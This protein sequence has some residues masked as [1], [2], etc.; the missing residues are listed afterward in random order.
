[1]SYS[2]LLIARLN[3]VR[4]GLIAAEEEQKNV[5]ETNEILKKQYENLK[6]QQE[7]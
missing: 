5:T 2:I 6:S 3:T 1:M 4:N 7:R